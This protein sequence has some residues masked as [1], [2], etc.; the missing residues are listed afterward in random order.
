MPS[1]EMHGILS[2]PG[3]RSSG[4]RIPASP[5]R[6]SLRSLPFSP[7]PP[8]ALQFANSI[9]VL[10]AGASLRPRAAQ[11]AL[12]LVVCPVRSSDKE[13]IFGVCPKT[14]VAPPLGP[15]LDSLINV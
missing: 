8:D 3:N 2:F 5:R 4:W 6:D 11:Q 10:E 7:Q 14:C 15:L 13:A 9:K 12:H 1:K